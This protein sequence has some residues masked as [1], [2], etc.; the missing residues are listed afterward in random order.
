MSYS[1]IPKTLKEH[2]ATV[3]VWANSRYNSDSSLDVVE[4]KRVESGGNVLQAFA[5]HPYDDY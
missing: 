4:E 3:D 1:T 5:A 2:H